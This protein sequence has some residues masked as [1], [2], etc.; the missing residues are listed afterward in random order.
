M[1]EF[2]CNRCG[3]ML[4]TSLLPM[5]DNANN[6]DSPRIAFLASCSHIFCI[7]C[8]NRSIHRCWICQANC[9]FILVNENIA[10]KFRG[11]FHNPP[12]AYDE[13]LR[14]LEFQQKQAD[15]KRELVYTLINNENTVSH[16]KNTFMKLAGDA[17][18]RQ[19]IT[20][21]PS[22]SKLI[23]F[24]IRLAITCS[25]YPVYHPEY[26][27]PIKDRTTTQQEKDHRL[28]NIY[29][30]AYFCANSFKIRIS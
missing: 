22:G 24:F 21:N 10:F 20:V 15:I 12:E 27:K 25:S 2:L 14:S 28:E 13:F 17:C 1:E 29:K 26:K 6:R 18:V 9:T 16:R 19:K 4:D 8:K 7:I 11:F 23:F 3:W 30:F 5:Q